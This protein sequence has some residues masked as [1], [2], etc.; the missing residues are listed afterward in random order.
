MYN[1]D[2][3]LVGKSGGGEEGRMRIRK[4]QM[5]VFRDL[6]MNRFVQDL[7]AH[8]QANF[9]EDLARQAVQ[10]HEIEP[11]VR[12]GIQK[13]ASYGIETRENVRG[14]VELM[15]LLGAGFD[16]DA[17]H[18]SLGEILREPGLTGREK[19]DFISAQLS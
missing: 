5:Q 11:F 16:S 3:K 17:E 15:A 4:A 18:S 8:L 1:Q 7:V 14:F 13:A 9:S 12:A 2:H 10:K 19:M 6:G